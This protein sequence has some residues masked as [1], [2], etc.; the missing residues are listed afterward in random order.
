MVLHTGARA[1]HR[2]RFSF[3]ASPAALFALVVA[4]HCAE[5]TQPTAVKSI[6][7]DP[8]IIRHPDCGSR[9]SIDAAYVAYHTGYTPTGNPDFHKACSAHEWITTCQTNERRHLFSCPRRRTYP[10]VVKYHPREQILAYLPRSVTK[11]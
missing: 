2:G 3:P 4:A 5:S 8:P 6:A 7:E 9:L 11:H 10:E 1:L